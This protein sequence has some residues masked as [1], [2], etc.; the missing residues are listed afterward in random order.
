MSGSKQYSIYPKK[1]QKKDVPWQSVE[2]SFIYDALV[3]NKWNRKAT[4]AQLGIHTTTLWRKIK[5][6][7]LKTPKQDGR[8]KNGMKTPSAPLHFSNKS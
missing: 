4:A 3:K 6:L 2:K 5:Q 1:I 8:K 7:N